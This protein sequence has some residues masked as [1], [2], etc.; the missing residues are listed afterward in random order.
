MSKIAK[1]IAAGAF[2]VLG[3]VGTAAAASAGTSAECGP[4][5]FWESSTSAYYG[6]CSNSRVVIKIDYAPS[7]GKPADYACVG[8][9]QY[10]LGT[11]AAVANAYYTGRTC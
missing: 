9:G 4:T 6:H 3:M 1:A 11:R 8:Y 10:Y 5:G 2:T 7:T